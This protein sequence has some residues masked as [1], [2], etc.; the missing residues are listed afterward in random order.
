VRPRAPR[1]PGGAAQGAQ[2][3]SRSAAAA[4]A[5]AWRG[6]PDGAL[7]YAGIGAAMAQRLLVGADDPRSQE[8]FAA[9]DIVSDYV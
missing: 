7:R 5:R 3:R 8:P 2:R 4:E 1:L 6:E 9:G